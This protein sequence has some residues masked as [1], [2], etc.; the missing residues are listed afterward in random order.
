M[1][2]RLNVACPEIAACA[3][4]IVLRAVEFIRVHIGL[5]FNFLAFSK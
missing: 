1:F 2:V 5:G 4:L 3:G